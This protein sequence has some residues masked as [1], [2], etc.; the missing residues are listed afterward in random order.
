MNLDDKTR[1]E[2]L[3][4]IR[5]CIEIA[6]VAGREAQ[7]GW[8]RP[9]P[10]DAD[11]QLDALLAILDGA[12]KQRTDA[13]RTPDFTVLSHTNGFTPQGYPVR[14]DLDRDLAE[15]RIR[16]MLVNGFGIEDSHVAQEFVDE[17]LS[18]VW[19]R[20]APKQRTDAERIAWL[21]CSADSR[22]IELTACFGW[23]GHYFSEAGE[24][25]WALIHGHL[26]DR[27][28]EVLGPS[29]DRQGRR[30]LP[31]FTSAARAIIDAH[32]DKETDHG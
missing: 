8:V 17:V 31:V 30:V 2:A 7:E 25:H 29:R 15:S 22:A 32:M 4:V 6:E 19:L 21:A 28:V 24:E 16:Q 23:R 20:A 5:Q 11:E 26:L 9:E 3:K 12:P 18:C 1:E 27:A 13:E 14:V 10:P